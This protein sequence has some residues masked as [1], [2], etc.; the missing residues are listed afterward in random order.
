LGKKG[1]WLGGGLNG[2]WEAIKIIN[3][4]NKK[5]FFLH[6]WADAWGNWKIQTLAR[7]L[8][9]IRFVSLASSFKGFW[10]PPLFGQ[11]T[12]LKSPLTFTLSGPS[13]YLYHSPTYT[14]FAYFHFYPKFF[15]TY[16]FPKGLFTSTI[17]RYLPMLRYYQCFDHFPLKIVM[18]CIS[19]Y[20][21]FKDHIIILVWPYYNRYL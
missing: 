6:Q 9:S 21:N 17:L 11:L 10:S 20:L 5:K 14:F 4:I 2:D 8:F 15:L 18:I 12:G 19:I 16:P 13:H 3:L 7:D 1:G